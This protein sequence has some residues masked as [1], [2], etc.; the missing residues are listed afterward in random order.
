MKTEEAPPLWATVLYEIGKWLLNILACVITGLV[1]AFLIALFL[2]D[3]RLGA[4]LTLGGGLIV[5]LI[6]YG[7]EFAI[8]VQKKAGKV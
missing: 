3:W 6:H 7:V 8:Y 4:G 2:W 1:I 5:L